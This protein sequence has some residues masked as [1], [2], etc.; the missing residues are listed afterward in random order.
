[1]AIPAGKL[2]PKPLTHAAKAEYSYNPL[3]NREEIDEA[4]AKIKVKGKH[5]A[6]YKA[7]VELALRLVIRMLGHKNAEIALSAA[8]E[9]LRADTFIGICNFSGRPGVKRNYRGRYSREQLAV[10]NKQVLATQLAQEEALDI[11]GTVDGLFS[12]LEEGEENGQEDA[13]CDDVGPGEGGPG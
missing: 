12:L 8:V 4:L 10:K 7:A 3:V 5:T 6:V 2:E 11:D 9:L 13:G 1:M